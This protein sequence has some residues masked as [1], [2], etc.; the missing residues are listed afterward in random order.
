MG[1]VVEDHGMDVGGVVGEGVG[2]G[3]AP[4]CALLDAWEVPPLAW[5]G[6]QPSYP[7]GI[8][9]HIQIKQRYASFTPDSWIHMAH[10]HIQA[11]SHIWCLESK[12]S[13]CPS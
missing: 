13:S 12:Y 2:V 4:P 10:I 8:H 5:D 1:L 3:E 7:D 9:A 11:Q 6:T